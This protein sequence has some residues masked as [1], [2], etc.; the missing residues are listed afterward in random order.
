MH[1]IEIPHIKFKCKFPA[2]IEELSPLQFLYFIRLYLRLNNE[3]NFWE[4]FRVELLNYFL[5][6]SSP[7][8]KLNDQL[9]EFINSEIYRISE[10]FDSFS[11]LKKEEDGTEKRVISLNFIKNPL[12]FYERYTGPADALTNCTFQ[13][14]IDAHHAFYSY[15]D[16]PQ[17]EYLDILF[18]VLYRYNVPLWKS[19]KLRYPVYSDEEL[20]LS[21]QHLSRVSFEAKFGVMLWFKSC[22][23][24]LLKGDIPL[25]NS[26]INLSCLYSSDENSTDNGTGLIGVLYT[27][28]EGGVFGPADQVARTNLYDVLIRIYQSIQLAKSLQK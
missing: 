23:E 13:Q 1:T 11:E 19:H 14:Y 2:S 9:K 18:S 4:K 12:P 21:K 5:A 27:I 10:V 20:E 6:F 17:P 25:G 26:V 16:D 28:A 15:V 24:F 7:M 8:R 22:E 3:E